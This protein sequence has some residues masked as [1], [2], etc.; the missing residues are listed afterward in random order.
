MS[1]G[2]FVHLHVHSE[3]SLLDGAAR[4]ESLVQ[5]A[6]E[7]HMPALALT[8]HGGMYGV[9]EFYK[10]CTAAAIKPILGCEV[11]V[12]TD[13]LHKPS[14]LVLLAANNEGY[15]NLVALVTEAHLKNF[16]QK[17]L[18]TKQAL[19]A[20]QRGLIATSA[21]LRGEVCQN[22]LRGDLQGALRAAGEYREIFGERF[23]LELEDHGLAEEHA[24]RKPL[25]ELA[26]RLNLPVVATNDVHYVAREEA[27][28]HDVLLCV[29][30][31]TSLNEPNAMRLDSAEFYLKS[32]E[33][34]AA[35]FA[36]LP[37]AL[38][39]TREIAEMCHAELDLH[40]LHFPEADVP[41]GYASAEEYLRALCERG[42]RERYGP[43]VRPEV[44]R[45]LARELETILGMGFGGYFLILKEIVDYARQAGIPIG[46]GRGSACGCLVA[47]VLGITEVDPIKH[48]LL[49]ERFLNPERVDLPDIDLDVCQRRRE[50][51]LR[52]LGRRF[53]EGH[54]AH[55][56]TIQR[57]AARGALRDVGRAMDIPYSYIDRL[58]KRMPPRGSIAQALREMPELQDLPIDEEPLKT[59]LHTASAL[60]NIARHISIHPAAVVISRRPLVELVPLQRA[61]SGEVITQFTMEPIED[62]GLLKMDLL[63]LRNL[64]VIQDTLD[65]VNRR[66]GAGLRR[67][68]IPLDDKATFATFAAGDTLGVFQMESAGMRALLRRLK[69]ERFEDI[70]AV[71]SLYRPGPMQSGMMD[72]YIRRRH[73]EEPVDYPHPLLR[74]VLGETFGVIVYQEQVMR[75]CQ[76]VAGFTL[77]EADLVRRAITAKSHSEMAKHRERFVAGALERGVPRETAESLWA[78]LEKFAGYGF[79]KAHSVGYAMVSYWTCYLKTHFPVEYFAALIT[80]DMGYYGTGVYIEE[81]RRKGITLLLPDINRSEVGF[82][83]E[84]GAIRTGLSV[85][86]GLGVKGVVE[87]LRERRRGGPFR[88]LYDFCLRV[89]PTV[90]S[91]PAIENLI[92][93]GAFDFTGHTRK[94]LL[95]VLGLTLEV[96]RRERARRP[97]NVLFGE[98]G[99]RFAERACD[100]QA[101]PLAEFSE[102]QKLRLEHEVLGLYI[103]RHPLAEWEQWLRARGCLRSDQLKHVPDGQRVEVAGVVNSL[104]RQR[105]RSGEQMMFVMLEDLGGLFEV[106]LFPQVY[107]RLGPRFVEGEIVLVAG[108]CDNDGETAQ[109]IVSDVSPLGEGPA[110]RAVG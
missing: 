41:P 90:L 27:R 4:I 82:V 62:L 40:S 59:Y 58:V 21:C 96:A 105:T 78:M 75:I 12:Q 106:V 94:Q 74:E 63:G 77:G 53:G 22:I 49:F 102:E 85:V 50:E 15:R 56:C 93:C 44:R 23:F 1:A 57:L 81:A 103:T 66:T 35:L 95:S 60:E 71:L 32:A 101:V 72:A 2:E 18:V 38:R 110:L 42:L 14:H 70:V 25:V 28:L 80:S 87:I 33:E 79:N 47:Y 89:D 98:Q 91:R 11:Y 10:A 107:R 8:D 26:R 83:V 97:Q 46:P 65:A 68:D 67:E 64:T 48:G 6:S 39:A 109:V 73:G 13:Y 31:L 104:R 16:K 20:H 54:V 5:R 34:M 51:L 17:P 19:A 92:L 3:Y 69:P 84:N 100:P 29:Q 9:V 37:Q 36:E 30:T 55:I 86:K 52:F 88:S 45:R 61:P 43:R 99:Q 24:V 108:R 76:E 7:L